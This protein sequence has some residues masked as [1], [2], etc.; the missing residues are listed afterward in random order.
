MTNTITNNNL[1]ILLQNFLTNSRVN[2][3]AEN[4]LVNYKT[5]LQMLFRFVKALRNN[6][7]N[8]N[9]EN[10]DISD[11]DLD[12]IKSI[13]INNM[14][15]FLEFL[16]TKED[17]N[18]ANSR[19]RKVSSIKKFYSYLQ[20]KKLITPNDNIAVEMVAPKMVKRSPVYMEI[21]EGNLL[22]NAVNSNDFNYERDFSIIVLLLNC[23][24]RREEISKL[25]VDF[26]KGDILRVIGKG[27]KER[28]LNLNSSTIKVLNDWLVIRA[29]KQID[30]SE[31][32]LFISQKNNRISKEAVGSL[33]KKYIIKAGLDP[34]KFHTHSLRHS[35]AMAIYQN[36][37]DLLTISKILGHE[38]IQTSQIY[39]QA[40]NK[41]TKS[42]IDNSPFNC[43]C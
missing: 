30:A 12:F 14:D 29:D 36:S 6:I 43:L 34:K 26:I 41:K 10:V 20:S 42:A 39:V 33:V 1:P 32:A 31:K 37:G 17:S 8:T 4:T 2:N 28:F 19:C 11:I 7:S 9:L 27:N 23:G 35:C 13:T 18:S 40:T 22:M 5:D 24:L 21:S 15:T 3:K 38:N 16:M 25:D